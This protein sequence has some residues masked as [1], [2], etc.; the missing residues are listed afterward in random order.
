VSLPS[1]VT[2]ALVL[3]TTAASAINIFVGLRLAALQAKMKAE[4]AALEVA[5]LKQL[6]TWKDDVLQAI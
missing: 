2:S 5:L 1:E 3:V 6:V 4:T